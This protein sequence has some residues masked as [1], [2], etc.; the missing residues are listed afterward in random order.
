[1]T[2]AAVALGGALG[3]LARWGLSD[4]VQGRTGL[5]FPWG[6]LA[7]NLVGAFLLGLA[8]GAFEHVELSADLRAF[9]TLGFLGAFTTFSTF[10][11]EGV[12]LLQSGETA[13]AVGYLGGSV[14]SGVLLA[15]LGLSLGRAL[16]SG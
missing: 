4:W 11:Y 14:V 10:S 9:L 15:V 7:V 12:L 16:G 1:M 3:A 2:A 5:Q 6:T 13:R 8:Y